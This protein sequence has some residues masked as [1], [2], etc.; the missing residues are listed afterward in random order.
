MSKVPTILL[1]Q[2]HDRIVKD[3]CS[4]KTQARG[5]EIERKI[6]IHGYRKKK[7]LVKTRGFFSQKVFD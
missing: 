5:K 1:G 4:E 6:A 7:P 2:K 3:V